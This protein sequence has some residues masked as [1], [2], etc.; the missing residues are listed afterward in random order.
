MS[1]QEND[2][3]KEEFSNE[4]TN[5]SEKAQNEK[6]LTE[7]NRDE[8]VEEKSFSE[9][10]E[11]EETSTEK[12]T[13]IEPAE[14]ASEIKTEDDK[15]EDAMIAEAGDKKNTSEENKA[16]SEEDDEN[17]AILE[18]SRKKTRPEEEKVQAETGAKAEDTSDDEDEDETSEEEGRTSKHHQEHIDDSVAEDS[19]DETKAERHDIPKKDYHAMSKEQ[20]VDEF[21]ALL[22]KEKVQAI[23]EHVIEIRAEFN[24]KFNEEEEEK[25]EEFLADG[26]NII[27][28]HYSTPLKKRFNSLYFDYREKRNNYYK[29]LKQDLNKNLDKRLEIIEELKGLIDVE[30]NINTTYKHF[31]ELQDRWRVA[32]P[33]PREKYNDVWNTYHHHVENFYDFLHLNRE[34]RDLDFKH[35]LDQKL[36]VIDRAEELAQETDVNRA[37]RELQMLHKMWKEELGPVAKEF[38]EDIWDR[39]SSA[40]KQ[41]HD[42]RQEYFNTLDERY[43]EN[44]K[45]KQVIIEKIRVIAD[46]DYK[47][48]NK[49]QQKIK[50][51]EALR[52]AFFNAGKVPRSKNEETWTDFK[53]TVRRFNRNKNAFY[54]NLKKQQYDNLEKKKELIKIAEDNKDSDDFK[55]VTPLMKKIQAD[56]KKVGHVPRKDS[57]K[58]WKQFKAACNHYFE[59]LH[60]TRKD[61][62][63]EEFEAFDK[64]KELLEQVKAVELSGDKK[65]DLPK[66]K[67]FIEDWK[68]LGRVPYNK[69]F[70][71]GKFNK[72]LDQLFNKLD[73]DHTKAEML[74]YENKVQALND[75]DDDKKLRNEHYFLTKKI[76]ETRA[77][78]RQ[79]E[80][81]LQFFSNVDEDNPLVQDVHKNI[82][83]QKEQLEVWK[84]KLRKIK[85]LY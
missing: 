61:E 65:Q 7:E 72:A 8:N 78:I 26:G 16:S 32:G 36:K 46:E 11:T 69:R 28:F 63:K 5:N 13:V 3:S 10:S 81:N 14:T 85:S 84:E 37:F 59:R 64:K 25:K 51:I 42:K 17:D 57:D 19:E 15:L 70:I 68:N 31:K 22:K 49:W 50:E 56:W 60:E 54:K 30:E 39:F 71:E 41:I 2:K 48:H 53:Q 33:I 79:L 29:Q 43:E 1:Q 82:A 47:S 38:R 21:E 74:K 12:E 80:N 58:V 55:T 24:A 83:N 62:N 73:V 75:A 52:E 34:F 4:A 27:D 6:K 9:K 44:W 40:T 76:E 35:N 77:E 23:K 20:L 66:I 67:Q 18:E 45:A